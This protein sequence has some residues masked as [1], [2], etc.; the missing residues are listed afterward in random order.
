M[1]HFSV[2]VCYLARK[3]CAVCVGASSLIAH[4]LGT[5][6]SSR[7]HAPLL[8]PPLIAEKR[9][10]EVRNEKPEA[11]I[12]VSKKERA[13]TKFKDTTHVTQRNERKGFNL[14]LVVC[15]CLHLLLPPLQAKSEAVATHA[16]RARLAGKRQS[17]WAHDVRGGARAARA[18]WQVRAGSR[19][20]RRCG[21]T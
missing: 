5:D 19:R 17:Y 3:L 20:G 21:A 12:P 1:Y 6:A 11:T 9:K 7:G 13:Q 2:V 16:R 10:K 15:V 8:Q 14:L 4:A 18:I